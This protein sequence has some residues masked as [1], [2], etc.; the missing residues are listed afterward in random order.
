MKATTLPK[1]AM[2]RRT[3][4]ILTMWTCCESRNVSKGCNCETNTGNI[5]NVDMLCF[6]F[7]MTMPCFLQVLCDNVLFSSSFV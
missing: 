7:C 1:G 3:L 6:K 2:K 5:D 4:V